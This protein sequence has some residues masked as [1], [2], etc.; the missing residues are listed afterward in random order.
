MLVRATADTQDVLPRASNSRIRRFH[1]HAQELVRRLTAADRHNLGLWLGAHLGLAVICWMCAW[2]DGKRSIY[3][4]LLGDYDQWDAQWYTTI[5]GHGYF[6]GNSNGP[7]GYAFL[8]GQPILMALVHLAVRN[9]DAAGLVLSLI[10]G[11]VVV[12]CTGRLG[13]E[14]AA[15]YLLTAPAAMYLMVAYSEATFLAFALP[16]WMAARRRKWPLAALLAA[17]AGLVRIDGMFLIAGL[18][19]MAAASERGGRIRAALWA[20]VAL[21]GPALYEVYLRAETGSWSA[22]TWANNDGWDLHYVGPWQSFRNS[23]DRAFG[24]GMAP[25]RAAMFQLEIACLAATL[26][27]TLVLAWRRAWPETVYCGLAVIALGTTTFYQSTPRALLIMWPLY[28]LTARAAEKRP[29][30]GQVYLW[31]CAP[32]AVITAVMFFLGEWAV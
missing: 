18:L 23:W 21:A 22:W 7:D 12:V 14:R 29:W 28:V 8:P 1:G 24:H 10:A 11:A 5:A 3:T 17:C 19:V 30:V 4:G 20:C 27:L 6:G 32:L 15:L 2:L 26:A 9:W 31:V 16:A 13:G 25:D